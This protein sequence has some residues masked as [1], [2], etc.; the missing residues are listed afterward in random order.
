M[1]PNP[2][3]G[4]VVASLMDTVTNATS[5]GDEVVREMESSGVRGRLKQVKASWV[6]EVRC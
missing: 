2:G 1:G 5:G 4:R 3:S 6:V